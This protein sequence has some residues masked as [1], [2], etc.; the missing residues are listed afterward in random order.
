MMGCT[1]L[2]LMPGTLRNCRAYSIETPMCAIG[3]PGRCLKDNVTYFAC[4]MLMVLQVK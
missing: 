2:K 4:F 1:M 3:N